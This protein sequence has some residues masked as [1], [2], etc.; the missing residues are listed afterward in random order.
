MEKNC[1]AGM[2][3]PK[4]ESTHTSNWDS[5]HKVT[6]PCWRQTNRY[7]LNQNTSMTDE[8]APK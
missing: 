3:I 2:E 7:E 8:G 5:Q 4:Y 1:K 6:F